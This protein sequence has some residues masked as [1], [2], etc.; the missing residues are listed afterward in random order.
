M[1]RKKS[2]H[3]VALSFVTGGKGGGYIFFFAEKRIDVILPS[4]AWEK[5]CMLLRKKD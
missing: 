3:G 4:N 5:N 2:L 1:A